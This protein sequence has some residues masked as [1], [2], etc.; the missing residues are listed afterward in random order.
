M[1]E[2]C[3]FAPSTTGPAH[4]GTLLAALLAWL[5]A[6]Q[7]AARFVL[8]LENLDPQRCKPAFADEMIAALEWLGID[9]DQLEYQD[10]Q[11]QRYEA[12]MDQLAAA[13]R[14]YACSCSRQQ[15][16]GNA[17]RSIDGGFRY[18]GTC[19]DA[20]LD[21]HNWRT[22]SEAVRLRLDDRTY[23]IS[24]ESGL[25]LDQNPWQAMGD[26]VLRRRDGAFA[27][28]LVVVVDDAHSGVTRVVRGR[29]L[30]HSS[31]TQV[32]LQEMLAYARPVYRH[33]LLLL[34]EQQRKLAKLHGSVSWK[35]L[36]V[37]YSAEAFIAFLFRE[38]Q[39][40]CSATACS[41]RDLIAQFDW[42]HVADDD[43]LLHW[44]DG[45]LHWAAS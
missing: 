7:H 32:A 23:Q 36:R 38:L 4:P 40:G 43:R 5:D 31:A 17:R 22:C 3:R 37:Q 18:P 19:R 9:W 27:Y 26:P 13:G 15:I 33:H 39:L 41:A 45:H 29:D 12:A 21:R 44:R 35:E 24:D 25:V 11:L 10:R 20:L 34:E 8:R 2:V 1:T 6:R 30:M 14:L 28:H 42:Q 16:R